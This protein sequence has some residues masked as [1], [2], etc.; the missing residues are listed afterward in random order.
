MKLSLSDIAEITGASLSGNAGDTTLYRHLLTDSRSLADPAA[1]VFCA[2]P[3]G[4]SDGHRYIAEMAARG[5]KAFLA[6]RVPDCQ[7][8]SDCALLLVPSVRDAIAALGAHIRDGFRGTLVAVTGSRAKTVVKEMLY[9]MLL[10]AGISVHRS[11]RSWNSRLGVPLTLTE[12]P[13]GADCEIVEV[14]IDSVGD[15]DAHAAMLRPQIGILTA[16]TREHDAGFGSLDEKIR[17]K[18]RLFASC[19]D[20]VADASCPRAIEILREIYPD[21]NIHPVLEETHTD[22]DAALARKAAEVLGVK[23]ADESI[24][25]MVSSRID[26]QDG[27]E[28]CLILTDNF[29]PDADSL[30]SALDFA[31][32]R[33]VDGRP[34]TLVLGDLRRAPDSDP[35]EVYARAARLARD[36]GVLDIIPVGAEAA[37]FLSPDDADMPR[38][39]SVADFLP[40]DACRNLHRRTVLLFGDQSA[41]FGSLRDVLEDPRHDT[42]FEIN[43]DS[44][45]HNFNYYRSLL[46]PGTGIIA[47]VKASAYGTGAPGIARTLQEQGAAYL[48]VAVVDEGV[49]LRRNGITMPILSL[50]PITNSYKALFDYR[51][52]PSV[53]SLREFEM[54]LARAERYGVRDY[55]IHIKLDTG[56]HRLGFTEAELPALADALAAQSSL[57]V[58]TVFSHLATA[59]CLDQDDY[60]DAQLE[61]FRRGSEYLMGRLP[62][63]V[64][65][66]ILNTAGIMRR[67]QHQYDLVRPGIGLYGVSPLP[68]PSP[69]KPV[70]ALVSTIIS[71]KHW[72]PGITIG[73][74]RRGVL[75]RPS[76][77]ATVPIGYADGVDRHF[78]C[79]RASFM[80]RGVACPTVGNI[81]MD[82]CMV[83]VTDVPDVQ[84]GDR[85][86]IFG[87][88][89][90]V[91]TL[92]ETLGTIPYE[93]L[94][95]VSPRVRR[96]YYRE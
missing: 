96:I 26:V 55:P 9:D 23:T 11:P 80:V 16:I 85:V 34:L 45:V 95:S 37:E 93:L 59:D 8:P 69:L 38:F 92:A 7:L 36:F 79:G 72:K 62:Y 24:L 54:L 75:T 71:I 39:R 84:I 42:V 87:P 17:E 83:D 18:A 63:P 28:G 56:M 13:E 33:A 50:N 65:R 67:P 60:T 14:G 68:G 29:T 89:A 3:T 86:E 88:E 1:T 30:A 46:H 15:M 74:G 2:I 64:R 70:A 6:E 47:M 27:M 90:P 57:R 77:I 5:V 78:S 91:E 19:T 21:K 43:L 48:A 94:T 41:D 10:R 76:V 53:F 51:L 73:Y 61:T 40:S 82:Q 20:I 31:R 22:T 25:P 4:S 66:H 58:A 35:R 52:E 81:C 32:R 49:E 44:L 12:M